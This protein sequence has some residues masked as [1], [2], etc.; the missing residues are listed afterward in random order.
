[1]INNCLYRRFS[2]IFQTLEITEKSQM[3]RKGSGGPIWLLRELF[4]IFAIVILMVFR[5]YL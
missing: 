4:V 2:L 5:V 1:M 3:L